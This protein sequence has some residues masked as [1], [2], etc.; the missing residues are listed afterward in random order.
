MVV[1][2][3]RVRVR[4]RVRVCVCACVV[5]VRVCACMCV[6][7]EEFSNNTA[8]RMAGAKRTD[9]QN[10]LAHLCTEVEVA[11]RVGQVQ[12]RPQALAPDR[13][14]GAALPQD[15]GV[16]ERLHAGDGVL[17]HH[18]Q[19]PIWQNHLHLARSLCAVVCARCV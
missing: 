17:L 18:R 5:C 14:V 16:E 13:V 2:P 6:R 9:E 19:A 10:V 7:A 1:P 8:G 12:R 11:P 3:V 4:V 15:R